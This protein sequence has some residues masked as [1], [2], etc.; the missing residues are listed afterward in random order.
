MAKLDKKVYERELELLQIEL[1]K[2]QEWV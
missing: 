2:L 1:V